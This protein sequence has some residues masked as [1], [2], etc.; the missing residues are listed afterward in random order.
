MTKPIERAARAACSEWGYSWDHDP[1]D[2][3]TVSPDG[4]EVTYCPRPSQAQFRDV[5]RVA[6][7]AFLSEDEEMVERVARVLYAHENRAMDEWTWEQ[8]GADPDMRRYWL[9]SARA[10][11]TALREMAAPAKE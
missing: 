10:A 2:D 11:I 4:E 5:S 8:E 9:A 6:I 1:Q 3:Q 7:T